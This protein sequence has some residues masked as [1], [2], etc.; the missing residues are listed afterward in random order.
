MITKKPLRRGTPEGFVNHEN[1]LLTFA[2]SAF[3]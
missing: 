1:Y 3:F 2:Y